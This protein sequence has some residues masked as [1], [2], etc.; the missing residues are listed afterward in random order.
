M[1][2]RVYRR[3]RAGFAPRMLS[4]AVED[5]GHGDVAARPVEQLRGLHGRALGV[6]TISYLPY[7][8][9]NLASPVISLIYGF[10]GFRIEH[11]EP[12]GE[13]PARRPARPCRRPAWREDPRDRCRHRA[14]PTRDAGIALPS[15]YTILFILIVIVAI[16][17]WIIPA[18]QYQVDE[19]GAR[20]RAPMPASTRTRSGSSS[21]R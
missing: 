13:P 2:S 20:S 19:D 5:F 7:C 10:T 4:R 9:F 17:T 18:G 6:A 21:T 16:A 12:A 3:V 8:F 14:P 1:P 15:A 11:I